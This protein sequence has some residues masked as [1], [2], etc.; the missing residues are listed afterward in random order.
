MYILFP[1]ANQ[2]SCGYKANECPGTQPVLH[3]EFQ[4]EPAFALFE[5]LPNLLLFEVFRHAYI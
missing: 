3:C 2:V 1:C 4:P 5:I